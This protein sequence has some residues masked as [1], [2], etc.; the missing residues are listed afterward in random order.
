MM[1][2]TQT[3][4]LDL[5]DEVVAHPFMRRNDMVFDVPP[6]QRCY[7]SAEV[8]IVL[9]GGSAYL[10]YASGGGK[11]AFARYLAS[12]LGRDRP[13]LPVLMMTTTRAQPGATRTFPQKL[14]EATGVSKLRKSGPAMCQAAADEIAQRASDSKYRLAVLIIDEAGHLSTYELEVLKDVYNV[15]ADRNCG[16][17]TILLG[18]S[19]RLERV[20]ETLRSQ[21]EF[22]GLKRRFGAVALPALAYESAADVVG[23]C[24]EVDSARWPE[25][26]NRSVTE[27]FFPRAYASGLR[28]ESVA[29]RL[30]EHSG[31][32]HL[33]GAAVFNA[34]RMLC[35]LNASRD[36]PDFR[37]TDG[38]VAQAISM[39]AALAG[40]DA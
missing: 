39:S 12:H 1:S 6:F 31:G 8:V 9:S 38:H 27:D 13:G 26:G 25:L 19:P 36:A 14:V 37:F 33:T 23:A 18:E 35:A 28:F 3:L 20:L 21:R 2:A 4:D 5:K 32:G 7:A 40:L 29:A 10:P 34:L 16:L 30:F 17:C 24:V 11:T 22:A 15:V